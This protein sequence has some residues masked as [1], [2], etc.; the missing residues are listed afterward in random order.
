MEDFKL[1]LEWLLSLPL[2]QYVLDILAVIF[3]LV[4]MIVQVK[5][6]KFQTNQA[7][8]CIMKYRL[9][10]YQSAK[11]FKPDGQS[12]T[13]VVPAYDLD[14]K[15]NSL[16]VVST[17]DLQALVQSSA[18]CAIDKVFEKYGV[19][20]PQ[21]LPEVK[22]SSDVP[23]DATDIRDDFEYLSDVMSDFDD[24]RSR[25]S[26]PDASPDELLKHVTSLKSQLD[27]DIQSMLSEA[28]LKDNGGKDNGKV[29]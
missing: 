12:F 23:F 16:V 15:T 8:E 2:S 4:V 5:K 26:M 10:D 18:D 11:G 1:F 14:E 3:S 28:S 7:K 21:T 22:N 13:K 17:K 29:S 9:E 20:P 25:Y 6:Y 19:L 24:L 27:K